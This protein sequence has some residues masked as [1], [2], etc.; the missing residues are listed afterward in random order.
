M[1][2]DKSLEAGIILGVGDLPGEPP[3]DHAQEDDGDTPDIRLPR[4]IRL[5]GENL[6]GEVGIT[7][8]NA[9][10]WCERL[11]RIMEDSGS[12]KIDKLNDV[13]GRHDAVIE[14][15]IT[16][17]ETHLMEILNAIADLTE[18]TVD[19]RPAHF[20]R[21]NNAEQIKGCILHNLSMIRWVPDGTKRW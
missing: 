17:S 2:I 16:V 20:T 11:A 15:E 9:R 14:L 8:D 3:K 12:T 18:D 7:A 4:I 19:F 10:G 1:S 21:H 13:I 5:L 6:W